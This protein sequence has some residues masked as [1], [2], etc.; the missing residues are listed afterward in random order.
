MEYANK[1]NSMSSEIYTYLNFDR[2]GEYT[3]QADKI[4]VAQLT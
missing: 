1:I 2:M 4:N 3:A